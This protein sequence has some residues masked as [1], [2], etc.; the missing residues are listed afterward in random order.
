MNRKIL[1]VSICFVLLFS[2]ASCKAKK[3]EGVST[4]VADTT[5]TTAQ[6]TRQQTTARKQQSKKEEQTKSAEK[7]EKSTKSSTSQAVTTKNSDGTFT[8]KGVRVDVVKYS[9]ADL[10]EGKQLIKDLIEGGLKN[11]KVL[12][13]KQSDNTVIYVLSAKK[14]ASDKTFYYVLQYIQD[15]S[16]GYLITFKADSREALGQDL[17]YVTHNYKKLAR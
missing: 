10:K 11:A 9:G 17:S 5:A 4:T 2:F 14:S 1:I 7:S 12:D 6:T 15:G 8:I 16:A 3:S 13:E